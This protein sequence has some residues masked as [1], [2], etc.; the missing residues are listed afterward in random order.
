MLLPPR[1]QGNQVKTVIRG[2]SRAGLN[3]H[4]LRVEAEILAALGAPPLE[5]LDD[6]LG[7]LQELTLVENLTTLPA[8][9]PLR[10]ATPSALE[11]IIPSFINFMPQG[12]RKKDYN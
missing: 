6:V 11:G 2:G 7:G 12:Y 3:L 9:N 10:H 5:L 1:N 8:K 4:G